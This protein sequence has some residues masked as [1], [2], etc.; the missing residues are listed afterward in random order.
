[1]RIDPFGSRFRFF[2]LL[3][4]AAAVM[5]VSAADFPA[6]RESDMCSA[7]AWLGKMAKLHVYKSKD[8]PAPHKPLLLLVVLDMAEAG[9]LPHKTLPLTPDLAFQFC[10]FWAIVAHRRKQKPDVRLPFHHLKTDGFWS[11]LDEN[12]NPSPDVRLTRFAELTSDFVAFAKE[13][14]FR[15]QARRI[16]I[17]KYFQPAERVALYTMVGCRFRSRMRSTWTP[18]TNRPKMPKSRG[19]KLGSESTLFPP[20]NTP[21]PSRATGLPPSRPEAL[22]KQPISTPSPIPATTTQEMASHSAGMPTGYSTKASGH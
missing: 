15:E 6:A 9:A 10:S 22:W 21:V 8:G 16:L 4:G 20:T 12:S 7:Q 19:A 18:I 17:A 5:I 13:P 2:S 11:A 3:P 14:A 1:M